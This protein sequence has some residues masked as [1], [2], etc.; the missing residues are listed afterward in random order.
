MAANAARILAR[1]QADELLIQ[2]LDLVGESLGLRQQTLGVGQAGA[3]SVDHV[4]VQGRQVA[5]LVQ[6]HLGFVLQLAGLVVDQFQGAHRDQGVL[7]EV[8]RVD[9]GERT[10][11]LDC[12][13]AQRQQGKGRTAGTKSHGRHS[14]RGEG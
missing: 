8:G 5:A 14:L 4:V 1:I 9:H 7:R 3:Q 6:Q 11:R 2:A 13:Q 12:Q 10:G